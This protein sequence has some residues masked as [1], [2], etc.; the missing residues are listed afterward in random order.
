MKKRRKVLLVLSWYLIE[1]H[2]GVAQYAKEHDWTLSAD[3]AYDS[4]IPQGWQ[5]DGVITLLGSEPDEVNFVQTLNCPIVDLAMTRAEIPFPRVCVDNQEVARMAADHFIERGFKNF[6]YYGRYGLGTDLRRRQYFKDYLHSKKINCE[7][8]GWEQ[9]RCESEDT[10]ENRRTWLGKRLDALPKPVALF[11]SRD[12]D[13]AE[14]IEACQELG[15]H[16]PEEV[17]ILGVNNN[18]LFCDFTPVPLSSIDIDWER[19]GYEGA[20]LLDRLMQGEPAPQSAVFIPPKA[21]IV[22]HSTDIVAVEN[23]EVAKALRYIWNHYTDSTLG[24]PDVASAVNLSRSKLD[25]KF[26]QHLAYSVSEEIRILRLRLVKKLLLET[27]Q[28]L[29]DIAYD[30]GFSTLPHFYRTFRQI[31][32]MTP[33]QY[34]I[35]HSIEGVEPDGIGS[36]ASHHITQEVINKHRKRS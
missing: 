17:A 33:R 10:W 3:M 4:E 30:A 19:A 11:T 26:R 21:L 7:V 23:V 29:D 32:G 25:K 9:E 8:M 36:P 27:K 34:R 22:R 2:R 15:I 20:A 28:T 16:V 31:E 12:K 18:E 1:I 24:V 5:G 14:A 13:G 35:R 6:A